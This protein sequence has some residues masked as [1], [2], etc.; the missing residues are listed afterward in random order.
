MSIKIPDNAS[1]VQSN[2]AFVSAPRHK[3]S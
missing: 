3:N 1:A 2:K